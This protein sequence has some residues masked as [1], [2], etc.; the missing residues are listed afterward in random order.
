MR[1]L[2]RNN[3]NRGK[4]GFLALVNLNDL[5]DFLIFK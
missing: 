5:D 1:P 3:S 2:R 4:E